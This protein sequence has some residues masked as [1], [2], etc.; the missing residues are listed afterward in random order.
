MGG[1]CVLHVEQ[2]KEKST[3]ESGN[4]F[5]DGALGEYIVEVATW[6]ECASYTWDWPNEYLPLIKIEKQQRDGDCSV[7]KMN[8]RY[9]DSLFS[10]PHCPVDCHCLWNRHCHPEHSGCH[11][12]LEH[13][14]RP[15]THE[16]LP[17]P[18][19]HCLVC[20]LLHHL[21]PLCPTR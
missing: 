5:M 18:L 1:N 17:L 20:C 13:R 11:L 8:E 3:N 6:M 4:I 9:P 7:S 14:S 2:K 19:P 12:G 15:H 16:N 10:P 21:L